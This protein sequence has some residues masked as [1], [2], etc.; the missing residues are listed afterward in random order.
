MDFVRRED[1][2]VRMYVELNKGQGWENIKREEITPEL[3]SSKCRYLLRPYTV[4]YS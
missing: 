4:G 3:I 2:L 1:G